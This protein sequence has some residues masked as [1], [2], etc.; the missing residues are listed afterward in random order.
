MTP[1]IPS[2]GCPVLSLVIF[3]PLAAALVA[4]F[5]PSERLLRSL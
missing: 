4:A 2:G 1:L 5:I 3:A